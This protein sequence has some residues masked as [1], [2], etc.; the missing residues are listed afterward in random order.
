MDKKDL[1]ILKEKMSALQKGDVNALE[2]IYETTRRGVY[3]FVYPIV[4]S[5]E[6]AE[7]ITQTTYINLYE[8]I[9]SFDKKK[10]P[11]NWILTVAKNLALT[12]V[13][14]ENREILTDFSDKINEDKISSY[15]FG[16]ID[17]PTI[18]LAKE[19]LTKEELQIV[20]MHIIAEYKHREIATILSL[21]LGT[22]TWKYNAALTKLNKEL[23][24]RNEKL[25]S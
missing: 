6:K 19:I 2:T 4:K 20:L 25:R 22:V 10:N 15:D 14:K 3:T 13:I 12:S 16:D 18:D 5:K 8:N 11:L 23:K 1:K 21:P 17:T 7:D 9:Q 24:K